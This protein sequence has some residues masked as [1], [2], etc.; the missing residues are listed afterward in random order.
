MSNITACFGN[1]PTSIDEKNRVIIP[2]SY[3]STL[4]TMIGPDSPLLISPQREGRL[5]H[6]KYIKFEQISPA[7]Y[8]DIVQQMGDV[9]ASARLVDKISSGGNVTLRADKVGSHI[10]MDA[11]SGLIAFQTNGTTT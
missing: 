5:K 9:G 4:E 2:S 6:I 11:G 1:Y 8:E 10:Y 7:E 3:R